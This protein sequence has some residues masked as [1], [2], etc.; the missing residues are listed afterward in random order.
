MTGGLGWGG[1]VVGGGK[2]LSECVG[3][4]EVQ[5]EKARLWPQKGGT[6]EFKQTTGPI[7]SNPDGESR[8]RVRRWPRSLWL[9]SV[10][11]VAASREEGGGA[12]MS[13]K[14]GWWRNDKGQMRQAQWKT[15]P[16]SFMC[17]SLPPYHDNTM[18]APEF[19]GDSADVSSLSDSPC[20]PLRNNK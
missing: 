3:I 9:V 1:S 17:H 6:G 18:W 20:R 19:P 10:M 5:W 13:L 14:M 16:L 15:E 11:Y 8:R 2:W 12:T 7:K 4:G